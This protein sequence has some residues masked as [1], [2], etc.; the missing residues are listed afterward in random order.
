MVRKGILL[1]LVVVTILSACSSGRSEEAKSNERVPIPIPEDVVSI[2]VLDRKGSVL[3]EHR[4]VDV[5][6]RL[7]DGTQRPI[8]E[9]GSSIYGMAVS[10]DGQHIAVLTDSESNLGPCRSDDCRRA[11][12]GGVGIP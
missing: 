5:L 8:Y 10:P 11:G 1:L 3:R 6:Q 9:S 12:S 4:E 2:A 7:L